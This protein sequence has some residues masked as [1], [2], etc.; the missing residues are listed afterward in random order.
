MKRITYL[1]MILVAMTLMS[2][3]CSKDDDT[4]IPDTVNAQDLVGDWNFVSLTFNDYVYDTEQELVALDSN[5]N[6]IQISLIDLTTTTLGLCDHRGNPP[7]ATYD[8]IIHY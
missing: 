1:A 4:I 2:F 7:L 5:Y 3:S 8:E 6:Y